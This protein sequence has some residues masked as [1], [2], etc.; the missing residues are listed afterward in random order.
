DLAVVGLRL[1]SEHED[2][3]CV[4]VDLQ[5]EIATARQA[6]MEIHFLTDAR[7]AVSKG[8]RP[9]HL[10]FDSIPKNFKGAIVVPE[11]KATFKEALT[12]A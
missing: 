10:R 2:E 9:D 7:K 12:P 1:K 4:T 8:S 11:L 3:C 6:E 5:T